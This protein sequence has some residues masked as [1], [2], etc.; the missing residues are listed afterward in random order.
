MS[1]SASSSA[2][3]LAFTVRDLAA[4]R[5]FFGGLLGCQEGY[6]SETRV[7]FNFFGNHLVAD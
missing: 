1:S 3:H 2:F 4:T 5:A 7:N 6:L